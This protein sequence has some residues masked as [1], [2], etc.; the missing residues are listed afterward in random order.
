MQLSGRRITVTFAALTALAMVFPASTLF[1]GSNP[2]GNNGTIKVDGLD[3]DSAPNNEPHVTCP[4]EIDFY[5]FDQGDLFADVTFEVHPP[6]GNAVIATD[7]VFIGEDDNSGGGSEAGLDAHRQYNLADALSS[8]TPHPQQGF[9]IRLTINADGSQ[10]ADT[11]HKIFW[12][13]DCSPD[14]YPNN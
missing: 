5:G 12:V 10:G 14:G 9:H 11:K 2:P 7:T 3:F 1:A 4:F 13:T 6:T 8:Y